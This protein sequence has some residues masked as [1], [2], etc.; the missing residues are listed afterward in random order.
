MVRT[1]QGENRLD[2]ISP[3]LIRKN[4]LPKTQQKDSY[5]GSICNANLQK[6]IQK[7]NEKR[8]KTKFQNNI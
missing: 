6:V 3:Y 2:D 8:P 7:T 1:K 5:K 4:I